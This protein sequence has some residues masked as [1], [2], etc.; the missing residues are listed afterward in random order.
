MIAATGIRI[1]VPRM[2]MP[3]DAMTIPI[4]PDIIVKPTI[5][6]LADIK[7]VEIIVIAVTIAFTI[8]LLIFLSLIIRV[9]DFLSF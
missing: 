8:L 4:V 6:V 9:I 3:I 5:V 1:I 2:E 7:S